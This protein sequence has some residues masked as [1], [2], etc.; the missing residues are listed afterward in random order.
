MT[1]G[2]F[3]LFFGGLFLLL[4]WKG[5]S[6][7]AELRTVLEGGDYCTYDTILH[8]RPGMYYVSGPNAPNLIGLHD[9]YVSGSAPLW[10]PY[11]SC[12]GRRFEIGRL[13]EHGYSSEFCKLVGYPS[14][15]DPRDVEQE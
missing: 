6:D 5:Q 4:E 3:I 7:N 1:L 13:P 12:L 2:L 15:Y 9:E 11:S 14:F 8:C 10:I